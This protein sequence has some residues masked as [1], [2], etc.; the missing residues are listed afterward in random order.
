MKHP[1]RGNLY[2]TNKKGR[3]GINNIERNICR[4]GIFFRAKAI[5]VHGMHLHLGLAVGING[6][7]FATAKGAQ[8]VNASNVVVV[9]MC[10][11]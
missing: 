8:V 10:E 9:L 7:L 4:A 5:G 3:I 6:Y 11:Q 2:A 1:Y